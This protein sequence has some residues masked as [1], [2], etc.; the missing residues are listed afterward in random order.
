MKYFSKKTSKT[1]GE[2]LKYSTK[3]VKK[4]FFLMMYINYISFYTQD[5][6]Q[7]LLFSFFLTTVLGSV[8]W[9]HLKTENIQ[10]LK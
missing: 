9:T 4:T 3:Q 6:I 1:V 7:T 2:V 5:T 8:I 10:T